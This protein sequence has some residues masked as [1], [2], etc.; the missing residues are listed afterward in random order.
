MSGVVENV[1]KPAA[2]VAAVMYNPAV[3]AG[4]MAVSAVKGEGTARTLGAP[5]S[6][7]VG[8]SKNIMKGT[9]PALGDLGVVDI[10]RVPNIAAPEDPAVAEEAAK[11]EKARAKRQAEIDI[12]T[13]RPGRGGTILTDQYTYNV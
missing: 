6:A 12:L 1:I 10:P 9:M 13:D 4:T 8:G 3:S 5:A 11:K 7:V 2:K